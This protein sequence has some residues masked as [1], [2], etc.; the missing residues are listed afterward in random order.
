MTS[1]TQVPLIYE[2]QIRSV[3][4]A[5]CWE[6]CGQNYVGTVP[7]IKSFQAFLIRWD[8][9]HGKYQVTSCLSDEPHFLSESSD[10]MH[11]ALLMLREHVSGFFRY[12][13]E[14]GVR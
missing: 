8:E 4:I 7:W 11:C 2:S 14:G 10:A 6:R 1:E 13:S 3:S 12:L 5:I 9:D